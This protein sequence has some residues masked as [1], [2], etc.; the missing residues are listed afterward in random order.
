MENQ[1]KLTPEEAK[2]KLKELVD[3]A[4]ET[5]RVREEEEAR[6][7]E[8]N[9]VRFGKE[10]TEAK[11]IAEEQAV[12]RQAEL[13]KIQKARDEEYKKKLVEQMRREKMEKLGKKEEV[14]A[15]SGATAPAAK[16]QVKY[17]KLE[18]LEI[19]C[20]QVKVGMHAYPDKAKVFFETANIY[21]GNIIKNNGEEKFRKINKENK[22]FQGR[23]AEVFAGVET[24]EVIGYTEDNGFLILKHYDLKELQ[25]I[26]SLLQRYISYY[27]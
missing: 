9:R 17:S 5:K 15:G 2:L 19:Q 13:D 8:K 11:R 1:P 7:R 22:A 3:K 18:Q 16:A 26:A 6:E 4:R 25:S 14:V 10:M 12:K 24:L 21:V 20:E 27:D 23:I